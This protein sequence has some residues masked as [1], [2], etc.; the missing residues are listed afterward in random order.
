MA[1]PRPRPVPALDLRLSRSALAGMAVWLGLLFVPPAVEAG[2][3]EEAAHLV[4]LAPLALVPLFV[5][6]SVPAGFGEAPRLL[7]V[8]SWLLLP[9]ALAAAASLVVPTGPL[10]GALAA[11]WAVPTGL[12]ALWA[13]G[14]AVRPLRDGTLSLPEAAVAVGWATLPGGAVWLALARG[15]GETAYGGL[16]ELLTAA[17]F[18]YAGALAAVWAGLLGRVVA[19]GLR[20]LWGALAVGLVVGF[21]GVA[22]GIA[23]GRGPVGGSAVETVGVVALAASAVGLGALALWEARRVDDRTSGL[24][25]AVS[26]GAL[27][28]AMGLA[29]WFHLGGR[30]ASGPDVAWM[31]ERHGALVAYGF[32]LWGALGWRRVR[33]RPL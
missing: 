29:L 17:H 14:G 24:M 1:P 30:F 2:P 9:G 32:G 8:A 4:I 21:W 3:A 25:I 6:A 16:I 10:A 11:L 18:H 13:L 5:Q 28:L 23:L 19:P 15:A 26:G 33:P 27:A 31:V 7:R 22:V 12:V 20:R